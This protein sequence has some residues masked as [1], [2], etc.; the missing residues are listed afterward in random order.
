MKK[1]LE[2]SLIKTEGFSELI[3]NL[4][5]Y[6]TIDDRLH[7]VV[8]PL[9]VENCENSTI[10]IPSFGIIRFIIKGVGHE[11]AEGSVSMGISVLPQE[12]TLWLPL[13]D[14]ISEDYITMIP[15]QTQTPRL[16]ISMNQFTFL[17]PVPDVTECDQSSFLDHDFS[18]FSCRQSQEPTNKFLM[19]N[20]KSLRAKI[21]ELETKLQE[22]FAD[23]IK[24]SVE[25]T[26][27]NIT[28]QVESLKSQYNQLLEVKNDIEKQARSFETLYKEEK[29]QRE[30]LE[31]QVNKLAQ[32]FEVYVDTIGKKEKSMLNELENKEKEIGEMTQKISELSMRLKNAEHE[33]EELKEKLEIS[34][35]KDSANKLQERLHQVLELFEESEFQRKLL[36]EKLEQASSQNE[37]QLKN[38]TEK[39]SSSTKY[40]E[41]E[42]SRLN[43]DLRDS[44]KKI[45]ETENTLEERENEYSVKLQASKV[46]SLQLK[47]TSFKLEEKEKENKELKIQ[48]TTF[49][50][51]LRQSYDDIG[52]QAEQIKILTDRLATTKKKNYEQFQ[53]IKLKESKSRDTTPRDS[54]LSKSKLLSE[55]ADERFIEYLKNYGVENQFNKVAE[56]V[57]GFGGNKKVS[58][59][60]KNGS[61]VC[62]VGGGYMMIDQFL[63]LFITQERRGEDEDSHKLLGALIS[64]R[65]RIFSPNTFVHKRSNTFSL[66][67]ESPRRSRKQLEEEGEILNEENDFVY[68]DTDKS[69][70]K[71]DRTQGSQV[72]KEN[73]DN[74]N[75]PSP[76]RLKIPKTTEK[77]AKRTVIPTIPINKEK[78]ITPLSKS[79]QS[80]KI[81]R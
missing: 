25:L 42:I 61:L 70:L 38:F 64:P 41:N 43:S 16:L 29:Y 54:S 55:N 78:V 33:K 20:N 74:L 67:S 71:T 34:S 73:Y 30:H 40:L 51:K 17:T 19:E 52:Q 23:K 6:I 9:H 79:L 24:D 46:E 7:E 35:C 11:K 26:N 59:S 2:I 4:G 60:I 18:R 77:L 58:V 47:E 12:G 66:Y 45:A 1:S 69:D 48:L 63:R 8:T 39:L 21:L 75:T 62:R 72:L 31:K 56:G 5:C 14:S 68:Q 3:E 13:Y 80:K 49:S 22:E 57:Y 28:F 27:D 36:Q 32:E 44:H 65:D 37:E 76:V 81:L 50:N 53:Q 10:E 15:T